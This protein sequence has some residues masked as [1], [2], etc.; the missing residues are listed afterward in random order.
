MKRGGA[1]CEE[2]V[3]THVKGGAFNVKRGC[4]L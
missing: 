1:F 3:P 4:F 2:V